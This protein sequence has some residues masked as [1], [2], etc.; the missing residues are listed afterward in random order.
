MAFA[1]NADVLSDQM[2][3][4]ATV[5][6]ADD[7]FEAKFGA[8]AW[9]ELEEAQKIALIVGA[10]NVLETF[11]FDGQRARR[12]QPLKWPR[13]LIYND[14]SVEQDSTVV[15]Q[16]VKQA[17]FEL[18]YWRLT[19]GDRPATD[20]ELFQLKSS[21]VGPLD[22]QFKDGFKYIPPHV[23]DLIKAIGPGVLRSAPGS[24]MGATSIAL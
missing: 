2:N 7:Y 17:T 1:L 4:Y 24:G 13:K 15:H 10:T 20:A 8:E 19:E 16:K 5:A 12:T 22:Y 14:E 6:E 11:N 9:A 23:V 3:C 18:A 21:K